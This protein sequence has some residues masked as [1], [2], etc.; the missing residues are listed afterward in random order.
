M[1]G[2]LPGC[3]CTGW[4]GCTR[5]SQRERGE[6]PQST[7]SQLQQGT[8]STPACSAPMQHRAPA[9]VLHSAPMQHNAL[10]PMQQS[11]HSPSLACQVQ[12]PLWNSSD[13]ISKATSHAPINPSLPAQ[14]P[15]AGAG[16]PQKWLLTGPEPCS[17]SQAGIPFLPRLSC[18]PGLSPGF[19][20]QSARA[21]LCFAQELLNSLKPQ[22]LPP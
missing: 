5:E 10:A 6:L 18:S 8:H 14:Q 13:R 7:H 22:T 11:L 2:L 17:L 1:P 16:T 21:R 4:L 19:C 3:S 9:P 15:R 12:D 20:H